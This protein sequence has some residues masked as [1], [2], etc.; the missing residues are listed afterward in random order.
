MNTLIALLALLGLA[1]TQNG[2][3]GA[4]DNRTNSASGCGTNEN[5]QKT[6]PDPKTALPASRG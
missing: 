4:E 2:R 1:A 6:T 5:K 3:V